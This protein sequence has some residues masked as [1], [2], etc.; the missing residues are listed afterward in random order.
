MLYLDK[1][2]LKRKQKM[3]SN[4]VNCTSND[5]VFGIS[6]NVSLK[7]GSTPSDIVLDE[8][9]WIF[10]TLSS[11]S[12]GKIK[13]G[14]YTK[15]GEHSRVTAV[16]SVTIGDY[17]AIANGTVITDNNNHPI[18]PDYRYYMRQQAAT[19]D[20][21]LWKHSSHAPVVIGK[22]V[23]IGD[24]VRIQKGV[25]IGDNS[26]IAA[27]S[28]VTKD[29]P[30]NSIAAGNPARI[31]KTNID[32]IPAPDSCKGYNDFSIKMQVKKD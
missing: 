4:L 6:S 16:E 26:I 10:G 20:S 14:K 24:N 31:V 11:Q 19:D 5:V 18:N 2:R 23:W 12:G 13:M 8:H 28:I 22:N 7:D 17:T 21:R 15:I 25:T 29:V 9:V 27:N 3:F 30:S 1:I 32:Q